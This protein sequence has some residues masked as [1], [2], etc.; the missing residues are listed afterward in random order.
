MLK[1]SNTIIYSFAIAA[2]ATGLCQGKYST[3]TINS[4]SNSIYTLPTLTV[5]G[6][7][8]AN[9]RSAATF[10]SLVSNLDFDP[11]MDFQSRNMAEAQGDINIRG[12]TFEGTGIKVGAASLIDPQTG[13][14]STELPIAPEMLRKARVYTGAENALRGFN[15]TAGTIAY[16]W[17]PIVN[18]GSITIGGGNNHL[19]FQRIHTAFKRDLN[20]YKKWKWGAELEYSRSESDGTI[21]FGDHHFN[22][23][24]A[25][26]QLIGPTSQTD[27]FAGYQD[28]FFG[29]PELYAA[30]FGSNE[31]E[32]LNTQLFLINHKHTY[33]AEKSY[34]ESAL[35]HRINSDHYIYDRFAPDPD[36]PYL[37][38][39]KITSI[40]MSG[41][42]AINEATGVYY[43]SQIMADTID[44]NSLTFGNFNSRTNYKLSV[45]PEYQFNL[46]EIDNLSLRAG[47]SYD[48]GNRK[49]DELS[50]ISDLTWEKV[51]SNG[52][53]QSIYLSYSEAS[54]ATGYTAL[55]SNPN[56]YLFAGNKALSREKSNNLELGGQINRHEWRFE[57]AIFH[58]WD[59][60]L[61][62]WT[63]GSNENN[64]V[65]NA[66]DINTFGIELI[67]SKRWHTLETIASYTFLD[68]DED[69]GDEEIIG[70]FYALNFANHRITLG[71]IWIPNDI[72]QVR[73][74]NEWR[75]QADNPARTSSSKALYT[76][77]SLSIFPPE[78]D[79]LELFVTLDNAWDEDYQEVPGTP[80]RGDQASCGA[81]YRW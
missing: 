28:K 47:A 46:N 61:V 26:F 41:F 35:Y 31:T 57:G 52:N 14:Y 7:E 22:R 53:S 74:D 42:H 39:S 18:V 77:I 9:I 10:K 55:N 48:G 12:G 15:S 51:D 24:S 68:K 70:S 66:V 62:D 25:R 17:S 36:K 79:N 30:P 3:A 19:N 60:D 1:K 81:T 8:T 63:Y 59:K 32:D 27:F 54:K 37:H 16:Q 78:H 71:A 65:A 50:I 80:G 23:S 76:N 4:E 11:R 40:A 20:K 6:Q 56:G 73:L 49:R 2:L 69:Y 38:K 72:V 33:A 21:K 75:S 34:W 5:R 29:W 44:S 43:A 67:A 58:R 45:L 13:H 64:R